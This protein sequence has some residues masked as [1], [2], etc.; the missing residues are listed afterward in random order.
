MFCFFS[1]GRRERKIP[2]Q[3]CFEQDSARAR[4]SLA[5]AVVGDEKSHVLVEDE[6]QIAV[7]ENGVAPMS[8][9]PLA[10][11]RLLVETVGHGV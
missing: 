10:I 1:C 8:D 4:L 3:E 9:D 7:E 2:V 11:S 5:S 6:M